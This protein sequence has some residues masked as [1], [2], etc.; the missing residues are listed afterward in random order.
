MKLIALL[1]LSLAAPA[2][3]E[4]VAARD[5]SRYFGEHQGAFVMT[6]L[7][8]RVVT[9][10][11]P[12]RCAVR[13][14]P[15]STFKIPNSLIGLETGVIPDVGF[16]LPWDGTVRF[17]PEWNRDHT[18]ATAYEHSAV[19]YYQELA[20]RVGAARM[21]ELVNRLDYGNRDLSGGLDTFWLGSSLRISADEQVRF[22]AR[23]MKDE[24]PLNKRAQR[25]VREIMVAAK[26]PRGILRGKTGT[27]W[28][29]TQKVATL[30][31]YVG[32]VT[33]ADGVYVFAANMTGGQQPTGRKARGIVQQILKDLGYL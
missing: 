32:A 27:D 19:W 5:L 7:D 2:L 29:T 18:L 17:V 24:L 11:E 13:R 4:P 1:V 9:S 26:G 25:L 8:G 28:D 10:Y 20:R 21:Q 15:C 31:W 6:R 12:A 14:P 3:A 30:G 23:L 16:R 33:R 22:L